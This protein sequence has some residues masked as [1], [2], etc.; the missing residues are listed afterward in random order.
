MAK[1]EKEKKAAKE[2]ILEYLPYI[3]I[4]FFIVIIRTYIATPIRVNGTSM[5]STLEEGDIMVLNKIGYKKDGLKRFD[6]VVIKTEDKPIIKRVIAF[7]GESIAYIDGQ[8]YINSK[9]IEDK[10]AHGLTE[11]FE[12][13]YLKEDEYY[14]L[15]D[16]RRVSKDSRMIGPIK[17][18]N[19][20]GKTNIVLYPFSKFGL[21]ED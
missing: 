12:T 1:T 14:V 4:I 3:I 16:N 15:G 5:V 2:I 11:D 9:K 8:L 13:I 7:P 19:I 10:Y 20:L 17:K 21:V 18:E 6:I